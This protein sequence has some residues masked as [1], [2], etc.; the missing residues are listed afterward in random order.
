MVIGEQNKRT[1]MKTRI[2]HLLFALSVASGVGAAGQGADAPEAPR[3]EWIA[4]FDGTDLSAWRNAGG[5]AP[6]KG[7]VI[8]DSA[9]VR[10]DKAGAIWTKERF[11]D[12]ALELEFLTEGNS[13]L[14]FRTDNVRNCVQ[15]GIEMQIHK[16]TTS[17]RHGLGAIYDCVAPSKQAG[18]EGWN[19]VTLTVLDNK[20]TVLLNGETIVDM[21]LDQWDTPGKNPDGSKNK[22]RAALKD[23]KRDGHIG[24]QDHGALVKFRN[25]RIK[26]I[27]K[28]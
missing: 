15:T 27:N 2:A 26:R 4:L 23:F 10:K 7:W 13:G 11:G 21:D 22:F 3:D 8:E 5:G 1:D 12:F 14:F 9:L 6:G 28:P 20:I 18:R 17:G 24:F 25:V 19:Q 16:P